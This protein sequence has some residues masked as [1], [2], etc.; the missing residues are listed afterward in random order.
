LSSG[1]GP[2]SA[3]SS[4]K[5]RSCSGTDCTLSNNRNRFRH[6]WRTWPVTLQKLPLSGGVISQ[7]PW[8]RVSLLI[9]LLTPAAKLTWFDC[10]YSTGWNS[11]TPRC[12]PRN[13]IATGTTN[14]RKS[15]IGVFR[16]FS[17]TL[18][19]YSRCF[20]KLDLRKSARQGAAPA[21]ANS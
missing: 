5:Y 11:L 14:S 17:E 10:E 21:A 6:P 18:S 9:I 12:T 16:K 8:S 4:L 2:A 13:H 1:G 15:N 19:C 3:L 7:R 20:P